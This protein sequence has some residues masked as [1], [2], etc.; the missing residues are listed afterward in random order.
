[1]K[2]LQSGALILIFFSWATVTIVHA[3]TGITKT[4]NTPQV[5]ASTNAVVDGHPISLTIQLVRP[6]TQQ[7]GQIRRLILDLAPYLTALVGLAGVIWTTIWAVRKGRMDARH[8]FAAEVLRYRLRQ[9]EE[10][11]GPVLLLVEQSRILY[12]KHLWTVRRVMPDFQLDGYRLLDHIHKFKKDP[13][14][15]PLVGAILTTGSNLTELISKKSGL[16]E[17]GLGPR[18][19][20]YQAHFA[21]LNA[22]SERELTKE[23]KDGWQEFGYYPRMLNREIREGFKVVLAHLQ[24][25][26]NAGDEIICELLCRPDIVVGKHRRQ[27]LDTLSFYETHAAVYASKFD[28][29]DLSEMQHDF[30]EELERTRGA[31]QPDL[32]TG[33]IKL[34]DAGCG[35]GRDALSFVRKGYVVTAFDASPAM[36]RECRRKLRAEAENGTDDKSRKA[37]EVSSNQCQEL[38]F[39][40][41]DF[42]SEFDG[43]WAAAALLHVPKSQMV[44]CL[45]RLVRSLRPDGVM[46]MSFKHGPGEHDY[47]SRFYASYGLRSARAMLTQLDGAEEI[48]V[49]LTDPKGKSLSTIRCCWISAGEIFGRFDRSLWVNVLLRRKSL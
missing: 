46:F 9:M 2:L 33:E 40:E 6:A 32:A 3:Q 15:G 12:E 42:R 24:N 44:E 7:D 39:D 47:D 27:L 25:Y 11:Y 38:T 14:I 19:I 49:W 1:M 22:A 13:Q 20:E 30:I 28:M 26:T 35:T 4:P 23:E 41:V 21:I 34:L 37:A 16:I 31:R 10:F 43:I 29:F 36:L 48:R 18:F 5:A 45:S 8:N 17:G